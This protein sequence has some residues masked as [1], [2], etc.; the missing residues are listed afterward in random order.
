M[1]RAE[2]EYRGDD[3]VILKAAI[4]KLSDDQFREFLQKAEEAG[5][6]DATKYKCKLDL[7]NDLQN[8][9]EAYRQEVAQALREKRDYFAD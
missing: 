5:M 3:D 6:L 7:S 2:G 8:I 4:E 9:E 1:G